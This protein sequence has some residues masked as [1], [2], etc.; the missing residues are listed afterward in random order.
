MVRF[1]IPL[2]NA[3]SFDAARHAEQVD[4]RGDDLGQAH[5]LRLRGAGDVER[6]VGHRPGEAERQRFLGDE[7]LRRCRRRLQP[8]DRGNARGG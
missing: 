7:G 6:G 5:D 8:H 2:I 3:P 4:V 1:P